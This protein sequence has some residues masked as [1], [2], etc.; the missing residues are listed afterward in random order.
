MTGCTLFVAVVLV[1]RLP[2]LGGLVVI[3]VCGIVFGGLW[4]GCGFV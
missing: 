2:G 3:A 4:V 1:W